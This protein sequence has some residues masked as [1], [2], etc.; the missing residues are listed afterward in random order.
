MRAGREAE[1]GSGACPVAGTELAGG[2]DVA[3]ARS[4]RRRWHWRRVAVLGT[5]AVLGA[6][7]LASCGGGAPSYRV[8]ALFASADGLYAGNTVEVLGVPSGTVTAV[9]AR[10]NG[11][12]VTMA[13][14]GGRRLP[15]TVD[16]T[17]TTP[18]ILGTPD[19]ELS[20]G[21]TGGP[22]LAPGSTIPES[23][24]V[25]P[26]SINRLLIDLQ[27]VL[28]KISPRS[29]GGVVTTLSQD[30]A[31]QGQA[32]HQLIGQG[33]GTL[34]LLANKGNDLGRLDGSL[35]AITGTLRQQTSQLTSLLQDYDTVA[36]VLD[37]NR[38]PLGQAIDELDAM[39][40]DLAAVLAP[41]LHPLQ[42]DIATITQVG[43]TLERN[44]PSLDQTL[45]ASDSLF[46][47]T[48]RGYDATHNWINL[49]LQNAPGVTAADEAG[50]VRNLLAG[51][52]RR[53]AANHASAFSASQLKTL[54]TCGNPDSGY[55][56]PILGLVPQLLYGQTT[57]AAVAPSAQQ[58]LKAGLGQIPGLSPSQQQAI[59]SLSPSQLSGIPNGSGAVAPTS[60][61]S[62][63]ETTSPSSSGVHPSAPEPVPSSSGGLLGGLLHGLT[64][65]ITAFGR[66]W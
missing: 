22:R 59:G 7:V 66:L 44:L 13:I 8:K 15:A 29:V 55:F 12:L 37:A 36:G 4:R 30:L 5:V 17:L 45:A 18:E 32:L 14:D 62:G 2:V 3:G 50:Q 34:Q 24:T 27:Q 47:A 23:R 63:T 52:C 61:T 49:N 56:N 25:V 9:A 10:G 11:V 39:S 51:I 48:P 60:S 19:V 6:T 31:G 40:E 38:Q 42:Q 20:P 58:M 54:D 43:R 28:G 53:L 65:M 1:V 26:V 16:A 21:Y 57:S 46:A 33:A 41:N 64:G 35:A